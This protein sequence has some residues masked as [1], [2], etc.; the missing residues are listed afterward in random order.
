MDLTVTLLLVTLGESEPLIHASHVTL[1]GT[2]NNPGFLN[3]FSF[4]LKL[5]SSLDGQTKKSAKYL[6]SLDMFWDTSQHVHIAH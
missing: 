6:V 4:F 2:I 1:L 3:W 5:Q